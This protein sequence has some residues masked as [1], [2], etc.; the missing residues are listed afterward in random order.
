M[1]ARLATQ[2]LFAIVLAGCVSA[3][4]PV[5]VLSP[6]SDAA[7]AGLVDIRALVPDMAEDIRYA[8]S[9]NFVGMPIDGYE[10]P[11]CY[12][13]RPAAEALQRV[14][15][16]LRAKHQRLLVF[17]CYRPVRA[18]RHFMRWAHDP[19]DLKT[20]AEFYPDLDKHAL[21]PQY[22]AEHSGHSR[23]AT[24]DLTLMQ[25]DGGGEN[26]AELDMGTGFDFFGE[27][28]H[29]ESPSVTAGQRAN[30][31]RLRDAMQAQGFRNYADEW[32][33]YTL[34]PEPTPNLAYDVPVR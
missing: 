33:H 20:K 15:A 6:A 5:P 9:H 28:A 22:I 13:L 31:Y 21:V 11:K 8:S 2:T 16:A 17:D 14:E 24:V 19:A 26:C 3:P 30:R 32:W 4:S 7:A 1:R 27:R 34:Q 12:L 18:V 23:G 29:T 10:A 25:C